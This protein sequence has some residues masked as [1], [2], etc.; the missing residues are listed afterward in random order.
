[1]KKTALTIGLFSLVVVATS[2]ANHENGKSNSKGIVTELGIDGGQKTGTD[3][4]QDV[5]QS[6][7]GGQKTGTDRKQ[8]YTGGFGSDSQF[9]TSTRKMD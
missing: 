1:M 4:K 7:D 5:I 8:D 6:I 2:F 3:R 9:T